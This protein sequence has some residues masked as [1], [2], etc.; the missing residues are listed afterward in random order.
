MTAMSIRTPAWLRIGCP[1]SHTA[2]KTAPRPGAEDEDV[3]G[4]DRQ[5]C[6]GAGQ[7]DGEQVERDGAEH[8]LLAPDVAEAGEQRLQFGAFGV[9]A[10]GGFGNREDEQRGGEHQC[11][12]GA[13]GD[14]RRQAVEQAAGDRAD[15]VGGLPGG[16]VPG[17]GVG[18]VFRR[19]EIGDQRGRCRPVE[20]ARDAEYRQHGK[21]RQRARQLAGRHQDQQDKRAAHLQCRS[22]T[23]DEAAAEAVGDRA[24][25]QNQQKRRQELDDADDAEI[26]RVAGQVVDLP[27]DGDRDDLR[28]EGGEEAR[29]PVG[30]E[31]P[32]A[33]GGEPLGGCRLGIWR[34]EKRKAPL[35]PTMAGGALP[36]RALVRPAPPLAQFRPSCAQKMQNGIA[37]LGWPPRSRSARRR[38]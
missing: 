10:L 22:Y 34:H 23:H 1:A 16:R 6:G 37:I 21:D 36:L 33:E 13:V 30:A 32:V 24:R 8:D 35:R 11:G 18:E 12:R 4:V 17:D 31:R 3:A 29:R 14:I 9:V 27:A 7:E 26:E 5:K 38:R 25:H 15:N 19:N 20:G 28:G 2:T